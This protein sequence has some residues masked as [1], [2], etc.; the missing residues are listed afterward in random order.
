MA[1]EL[2][3]REVSV[4]ETHEIEARLIELRGQKVLIDRDVAALYGVETRRVNEAVRNNPD[5]FPQG[6]SFTLQNTEK[7]YL[8]ENFD[9]LKP[10]KTSTV[11][12]RAFTEKGL[13]MM[14]TILKSPR[15][16][17]VTIAIIETFAKVRGLKRELVE[18]H[19][20]TD[21]DVQAE[22]MHHFGEVLTDIVMP[23]L[24]TTETES[25]LEINFIIGKITHTVKRVK[26]DNKK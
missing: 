23:D 22:K 9:R 10:L 1:K 16:T 4:I 5:K 2:Q 25:S 12:P 26:K 11:E 13:Y 18:L 20:E 7:Q 6:Y 19:K 21:K 8:V 14:A 17:A 3:Q 24:E 15:A